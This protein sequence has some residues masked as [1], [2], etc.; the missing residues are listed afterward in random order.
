MGVPDKDWR[1]WTIFGQP[2]I[3]KLQFPE[4]QRKY[5]GEVTL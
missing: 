4:T 5:I 3:E 2:A 1:Q